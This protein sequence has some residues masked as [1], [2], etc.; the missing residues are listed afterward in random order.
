MGPPNEDSIEFARVVDR[1]IRSSKIV[2][3]KKFKL[4]DE[5]VLMMFTDLYVLD[6]DGN[7]FDTGALAAMAAIM[8]ARLP[9]IEIENEKH[10]IIWGEYA[11]K[12]EYSDLVVDSTFSMIG[13]KILIDP[14][15]HEQ[16][17]MDAGMVVS[18]VGENICTLQKL[19]REGL[20]KD[21]ILQMVDI[22]FDKAKELKT[23]L[24]Q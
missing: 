16:K 11:G 17:G 21:Q 10:K 24:K 3:L 14:S 23:H 18:T 8:T 1:G 15:S 9:K 2:D 22:A 12:L 6:Y 20:T 4:D 19:G 7:L 5:H 13:D